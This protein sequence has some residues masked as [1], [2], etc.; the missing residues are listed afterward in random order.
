MKK[1]PP[2]LSVKQV[3]EILCVS[4]NTAYA[5][6][7][8]EQI[9]RSNNYL[10]GVKDSTCAAYNATIRT[11]IKPGLGAIRIDSPIWFK[12]SITASESLQSV[13]MQFLP[14]R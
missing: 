12:A 3:A 7:R 8:F 4:H 2:V 14:R 10:G 1:Y 11:H 5:L 9:Y 13:G 6:I